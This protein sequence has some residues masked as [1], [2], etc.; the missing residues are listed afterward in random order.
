[1]KNM[2]ILSERV[3]QQGL[4]L[5][6]QRRMVYEELSRVDTHP[7]AEEVFQMVKRRLPQVSLGTI[8]RNLKA[9]KEMGLVSENKYARNYS[10]FDARL[11]MHHH[12]TCLKCDR[13]F[14]LLEPP[15]LKFEQILPKQSGFKV[16]YSRLEFYGECPNCSRMNSF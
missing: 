15:N 1:M 13:V 8:Y 14:D 12:F 4:R 9:L 3:R 5:T 6:R 7:R 10:R 2:S 16:R 11:E